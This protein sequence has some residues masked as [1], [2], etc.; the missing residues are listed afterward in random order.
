MLTQLDVITDATAVAYATLESFCD[1]TPAL[2]RDRKGAVSSVG[3]ATY[4]C[5][6][7]SDHQRQYRYHHS[8]MF[9]PGIHN[10]MSDNALR[11]HLLSSLLS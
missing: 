3:P 6:F 1:N 11:S 10:V 8:S 9:L 7:A 2:S 5:Q 4:L